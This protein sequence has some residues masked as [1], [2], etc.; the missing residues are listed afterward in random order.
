MNRKIIITLL[1][2]LISIPSLSRA[3]EEKYRS[4]AQIKALPDR[5]YEQDFAVPKVSYM[6]DTV[7]R[8]CF[9]IDRRWNDLINIECADLARRSEWEPVLDWLKNK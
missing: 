5:W 4:Q 9:F 6:V 8:Q 1:V 7:T 2:L 3:A